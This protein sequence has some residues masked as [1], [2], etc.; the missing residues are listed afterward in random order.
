MMKYIREFLDSRNFME[1]ETPMMNTIPGGAAARPFVTHHNE[2]DMQLYMRIAPELYL[3]QLVVGGL[4]RVYEIG[5][6]F[7]N[8]GIDLTHNP[9]F[10]TVECYEAYA[11]Y[12]D[13]MQRVEEMLSGLVLAVNG[14]YLLRY[15]PEGK[16]GREIEIDF[17]PP[18]R[19]LPMLDGIAEKGVE[20]PKEYDLESE[21][22][23]E[24]LR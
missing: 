9:E 17:T 14:S 24:W 16:D 18:F 11:D 5:R 23:S 10:T 21:E 15:H 1:V 19:R 7:R 2:L 20:L 4:E 8:E 12:Y 3:K 6:Q 13:I 22:M